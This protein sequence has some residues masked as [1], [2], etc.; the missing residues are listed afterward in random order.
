MSLEDYQFL[1][2][3]MT[4]DVNA[5]NRRETGEILLQSV[6]QL[7]ISSTMIRDGLIKGEEVCQWMPED[8]CQKLRGLV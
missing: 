8:V 3:K 6:P 4:S 2:A 5:L 7:D 1:A